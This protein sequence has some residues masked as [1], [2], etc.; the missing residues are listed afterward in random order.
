MGS[1]SKTN[2]PEATRGGVLSIARPDFGSVGAESGFVF[3]SWQVREIAAKSSLR[4]LPR[5]YGEWRVVRLRSVQLGS[6]L[7]E[8]TRSGPE[9][10]RGKRPAPN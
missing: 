7:R 2:P 4:R 1:F 5:E 6:R 10:V 8:A 3:G 9:S